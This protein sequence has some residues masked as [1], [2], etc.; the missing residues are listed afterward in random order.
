MEHSERP[1]CNLRSCT[2]PNSVSQR[3]KPAIRE[4]WAVN[5]LSSPRENK[6]IQD[7]IWNPLSASYINFNLEISVSSAV[8]EREIL[9]LGTQEKPSKFHNGL[10]VTSCKLSL[11]NT[12]K[13]TLIVTI[14]LARISFLQWAIMRQEGIF[15]K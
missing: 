3:S 1:D 15:R 5:Q 8:T 4:L 2:A 13:I 10:S 7:K 14:T 6:R 11:R 12:R 9:C